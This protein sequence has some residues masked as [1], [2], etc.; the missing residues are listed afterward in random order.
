MARPTQARAAHRPHLLN[1]TLSSEQ[2][3]RVIHEWH[4]LHS[5][6]VADSLDR[7]PGEPDCVW[8]SL[9]RSNVGILAAAAWRVGIPCVEEYS[10]WCGDK[11]RRVDLW[12]GTKDRGGPEGDGGTHIEA[13]M[14]WLN[15]NQKS[16][17]SRSEFTAALKARL[18]A[19]HAQMEHIKSRSDRLALVFV[20][21][22][23]R[24]WKGARA[25]KLEWQDFEKA[26]QETVRHRAAA[27]NE[28]WVS[29]WTTLAWPQQPPKCPRGPSGR[30]YPGALLVGNLRPAPRPRIPES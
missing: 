23:V 19:A 18:E 24:T 6:Y 10:D 29:T 8:W 16:R 5:A 14:L 1:G 9:E 25:W 11:R 30:F 22:H 3:R 2:L 4:N 21:P 26:A 17:L 7:T 13:K 27:A 15:A 12:L 28:E 20:V